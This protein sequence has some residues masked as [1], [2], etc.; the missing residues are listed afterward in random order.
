MTTPFASSRFP[1][2]K[3]GGFLVTLPDLPG[4]VADGETVDAAIAEAHDA[5]KAWAAAE[6]RAR[7]GH[8]RVWSVTLRTTTLQVPAHLR[9]V[10]LTPLSNTTCRAQQPRRAHAS[11]G[12]AKRL[13]RLS[14]N[15]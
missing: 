5:F 4:C 15:A 13:L 6:E 2:R 1:A 3:G 10:R 9:L 12:L 8:S 14:S 11:Q 7:W